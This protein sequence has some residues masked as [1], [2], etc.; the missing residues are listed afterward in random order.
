MARVAFNSCSIQISKN[1]KILFLE[2][3]L[4]RLKGQSHEKVCE[5]MTSRIGLRFA[6]SFT[7]FKIGHLLATILQFVKLVSL[8]CKMLV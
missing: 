3:N 2:T 1:I 5:I 6:N 8:I 4:I 7:N